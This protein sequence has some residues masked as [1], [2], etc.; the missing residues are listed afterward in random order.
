MGIDFHDP[1]VQIKGP[2]LLYSHISILHPLG[3]SLPVTESVCGFVAICMTLLRLWI[4]RTRYWW[5][6]A[7]A[8]FSL[9]WY[10][11]HPPKCDYITLSILFSSLFVQVGN[12][13]HTEN[14][15][16]ISR[17]NRIVTYYLSAVTF[18]TVIWSA[19]ISILFSIIRIDP[20]PFMRHRLKWLAAVFVGAIGFFIAQLFWI[21]ENHHNDWKDTASP[22]CHLPEQVPIC[23]LVCTHPFPSPLSLCSREPHI[24]DILVDLSLILLPI[25]LFRRI[26]DK[27]LRWRLSFIFSTSSISAVS[28]LFIQALTHAA[29]VTT[30]VSLVHAP[31][32]LEGGFPELIS[33]LVE[34]CMSLTVANIPVVAGASIRCISGNLRDANDDDHGQRWSALRFR[35][36]TTRSSGVNTHWSTG[37]GPS[38]G[39]VSAGITTDITSTTPAAMR[40]TSPVYSVGSLGPDEMFT[41]AK[42]DRELNKN[43]QRGED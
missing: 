18:Y 41:G 9:L 10:I 24:A 38:R 6:D 1:L 42:M 5:D 20:D 40:E 35:T 19:R 31:Y 16:D 37:F 8:F 30:I 7:W 34:D 2:F 17:L 11:P 3:L 15:S 39:G 36:R 29:V 26:Q 22:Q 32:I 4:R 28:L 23:Q 25:R 27:R 14:P 43:A 21:C 12:I 13:M 33:G